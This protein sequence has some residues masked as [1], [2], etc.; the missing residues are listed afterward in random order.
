M[1]VILV[2]SEIMQWYSLDYNIQLDKMVEI[3]VLE[4]EILTVINV[5]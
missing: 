3:Q 1:V 2:I 5:S 4:I